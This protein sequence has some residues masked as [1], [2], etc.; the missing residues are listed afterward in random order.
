MRFLG[1]AKEIGDV[2]FRSARADRHGDD[3]AAALELPRQR[4]KHARGDVGH[5][6]KDVD[7]VN[8]D[9]RS[10][11]IR[12]AEELRA[13]GCPRHPQARI[14]EPARPIAVIILQDLP[15]LRVNH[16]GNTEGGCDRV[17]RDIVVRRTDAARRE[18]VIVRRAQHIHCFS[19]PGPVVGNDADLGEPN[20]LL[21]QPDSDL[22]DVLV[23]RPARQDLVA[24]DEQRGGPLSR[25]SVQALHSRSTSSR[26]VPIL[27]P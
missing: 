5:T 9:A 17:H 20:P 16:H 15:R 24:D 22:A 8:L 25:F 14:G 13:F 1:L 21:V 11:G 18:E 10:A 2:A 27:C 6:G 26:P 19:D 4:L 3:R 7:I 23:L 12:V